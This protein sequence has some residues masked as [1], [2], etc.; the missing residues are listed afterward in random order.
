MS[1]ADKIKDL[2]LEIQNIA[3][4]E[5]AAKNRCAELKNLVDEKKRRSEALKLAQDEEA[6]LLKE[7]GLV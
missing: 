3:S 6:A 1:I 4:D 5:K 2:T 7:L